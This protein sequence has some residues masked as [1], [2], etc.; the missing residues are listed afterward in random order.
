MNTK[1]TVTVNP[2]E[3]DLLR[4]A[5]DATANSYEALYSRGSTAD[6]KLKREARE[7]EAELRV[8]SGKLNS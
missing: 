1:V 7:K 8:L 3:F 4:E 6:P 2:R 5:V